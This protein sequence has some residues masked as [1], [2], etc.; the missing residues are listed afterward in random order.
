MRVFVGVCLR[1]GEIEGEKDRERL[2][3]RP[4]EREIEGESETQRGIE[5][6]TD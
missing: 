5:R 4:R 1:E 6:Q 2:G 3:G